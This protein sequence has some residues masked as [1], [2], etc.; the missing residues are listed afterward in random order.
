MDSGPL[1]DILFNTVLGVTL[2]CG[3]HIWL[4]QKTDIFHINAVPNINLCDII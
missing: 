1:L 4:S 2:H 3:D